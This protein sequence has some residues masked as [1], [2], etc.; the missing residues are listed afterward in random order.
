MK[1]AFDGI[2]KNILLEKMLKGGYCPTLVKA[3][4]SLLTGTSITVQGEA[5][6]T[7]KG[8][9]QGSC[10]SPELFSIYIADLC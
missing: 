9:P 5:I 10:I 1:S 4:Q 8:S 3:V 2:S 6:N 7:E